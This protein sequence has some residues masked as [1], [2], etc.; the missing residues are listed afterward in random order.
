[1]EEITKHIS[2]TRNVLVKQIGY[3]SILFKLGDKN[4]VSTLF[5]KVI[6][7]KQC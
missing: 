5:N 3:F 2:K 7:I 4:E 6:V 1:M